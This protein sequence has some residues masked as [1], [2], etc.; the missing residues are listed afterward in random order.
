MELS[1]T[2]YQQGRR[3]VN[4]Y[5]KGWLICSFMALLTLTGCAR[6][7][8]G[9]TGILK[10][11][12]GSIDL[13]PYHGFNWVIFD[14]MVG[15]VDSTETR[16]PIDGLQPSDTNGVQLDKLDIV[17]SFRLTE[18]K[19]PAFYIQTKELDSYTD[20]SGRSITTVG[21]KVLENIIRH[22][23]QEQTKAQSLQALAGHL[24]QYEAGIL[25]Q[26]QEELNKGYPGVFTLIRV[27]VN[28]FV[29]PASIREQANKTASLASEAE[30]NEAEQRLIVQRT[31]L[32]KSK[33]LVEA[34]ALR[35]AVDQTHLSPEQLI[36]WKNARAYETQAHAFAERAIPVMTVAAPA[37]A[38]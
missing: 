26:A 12:G 35:D 33:A 24:S 14:S 30:R 19:I 4:H 3:I 10:H 6:V 21:L 16:V 1:T 17:V 13:E 7:E 36:A 22:S 32:E 27:N 37:A 20:D 11:F 23:V 38:K 8:T 29:P 31:Q 34:Q 15:E 25:Q 28:H 18:D 9:S 2:T 5:F